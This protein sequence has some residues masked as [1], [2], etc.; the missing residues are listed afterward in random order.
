MNSQAAH[1]RHQHL[2]NANAAVHLLIIFQNGEIGASDSQAG[3]VDR[4]KE[5]TFLDTG[6]G[7]CRTVA[8]VGT[9]CLEAFEVGAGADLAIQPLAGQPDLQVVRFCRGKAH[10]A[11]A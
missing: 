9:A 7:R 11:G 5:L 6:G 10:V 4:V 1:V 8:D 3:A 2:R